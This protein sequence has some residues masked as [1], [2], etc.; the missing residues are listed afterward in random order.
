[1][2]DV[3]RSPLVN[4]RGVNACPGAA[5]T[6]DTVKAAFTRDEDLFAL[7]GL[8]YLSPLVNLSDRKLFARQMMNAWGPVLGLEEGENSRALEAGFAALDATSATSGAA[9]ARR[10]ISSRAR[11]GSASSSSAVP[12]TTIPGSTTAFSSNCR[13]SGYPILSQST[14]PLDEDLL[15]ALFAEEVR[16]G[17]I[18]HPLEITDVWKH[19]SSAS[20]N[21]KLWAAKFVA[22]H[23]NLVALELS[24]FKCGHDAPI[25]T[26]IERIMERSG[27]PYFAFKE[28]DENK[29]VGSIKLRVETI[30]YF[31]GRYREELAVA[32][33]AARAAHDLTSPAEPERR[34][35]TWRRPALRPV[36]GTAEYRERR[37]L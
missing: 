7:H 10:S 19:A 26:I 1:M 5:I 11:I 15:D 35:P 3:L 21:H 27:T 22:R 9:P 2:F 36:G 32:H 17:A 23:P 20:T 25:Y 14:L 31:L 16:A 12:I 18:G 28:I 13:R 29:P 37:N 6:P 24:N 30:H 34:D 33:S 8:R 4:L